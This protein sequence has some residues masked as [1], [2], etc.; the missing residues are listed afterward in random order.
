MRSALCAEGTPIYCAKPERVNAEA[1]CGA[2]LFLPSEYR[3]CSITVLIL[4]V[5]MYVQALWRII[6]QIE[7]QKTTATRTCDLAFLPT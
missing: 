6:I 1:R 7:K 4:H 3:N 2:A 5:H